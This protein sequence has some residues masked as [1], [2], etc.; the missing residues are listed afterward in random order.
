M[1]FGVW[2]G[3]G[4]GGA[5]VACVTTHENLDPLRLILMQSY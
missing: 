3:G 5:Q 2:G 4:G 1:K